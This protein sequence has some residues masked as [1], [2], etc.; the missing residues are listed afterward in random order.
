MATVNEKTHESALI[1][2]NIGAVASGIVKKVSGNDIS[3]AVNGS[4]VTAEL[5]QNLVY[6]RVAKAAE[7][8]LNA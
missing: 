2:A 3:T 7:Q 8:E 4:P 6:R 1:L 5:I